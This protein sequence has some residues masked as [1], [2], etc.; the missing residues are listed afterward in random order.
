M[1]NELEGRSEDGAAPAVKGEHTGGGDGLMGIS[2]AGTGV[3]GKSSTGRGVVAESDTNFGLRAV[4][5]KTAGVRGSS[6]DGRGVEG[7]STNSDGMVGNSEGAGAGVMGLSN[8]GV[9]VHG[10][11]GRLARLFEGD[12]EITGHLKI[13]GDCQMQGGADIAEQFQVVGALEAEAGCVVI[14]AGDDQIRVSDQ[15]YDRRVAGVVSGAGTY[16]P[17]LIL[18]QRL[19]GARRSLALTGKAWCKVDASCGSVAVG[20]LLTTSPTPGHAMRATDERRA[21]GAV[22]GKALGSLDSGRGLIAIL[23]ALQ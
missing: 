6:T 10:K 3:H 20:D 5:V 22:I 9:G 15:P 16:R 12:V 21:F 19:D 7:Q 8:R 18:D 13:A 4:S 2:D 11:G 23:V 17:A 14:V 1:A